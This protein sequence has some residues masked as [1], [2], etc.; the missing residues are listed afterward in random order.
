M[1]LHTI[2][3]ICRVKNFVNDDYQLTEKLELI[4]LIWKQLNILKENYKI[5]ERNLFQF[6]S[7]PPKTEIGEIAKWLKHFGEIEC[8]KIAQEMQH[9]IQLI[10][11]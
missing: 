10:R 7:T 3:R 9:A 1:K 8:P 2:L 6:Q 4:Y 5:M 11:N